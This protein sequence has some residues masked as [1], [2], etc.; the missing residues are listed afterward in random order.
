[1]SKSCSVSSS[2]GSTICSPALLSMECRTGKIWDHHSLIQPSEAWSMEQEDDEFSS[3]V[4]QQDRHELLDFRTKTAGGN[5]QV[6]GSHPSQQDISTLSL[7][8]PPLIQG[9]MRTIEDFS[10]TS[11]RH[12]CLHEH[13][14]IMI[15]MSAESCICA[16]SD[17]QLRDF[18]YEAQQARHEGQ[19]LLGVHVLDGCHDILCRLLSHGI[20]QDG[21]E[22]CAWTLIAHPK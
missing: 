8:Y 17:H 6:P 20:G 10:G 7:I 5:S 14:V 13:H 12:M 21:G 2:A 19:A 3:G 15:Q 11:C 1:M 22:V 18:K 16:T 9:L 4:H